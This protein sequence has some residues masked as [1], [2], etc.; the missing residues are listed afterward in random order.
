MST[1]T[2]SRYRSVEPA[3]VSSSDFKGTLHFLRLFLRRDRIALP[4]WILIF[5]FAPALY[6]A[7]IADIYTSDAQLAEFAA[8]TAASPAQIA[9]YGPIF[10][11]SLG[12]VGV[13]K[14]GIYYTLIGW[15]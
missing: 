3:P 5:A 8:T 14:A 11:S 6:V 10:N 7:S 12:S 4:L 1:A 13:W 2:V 15:W 9:M